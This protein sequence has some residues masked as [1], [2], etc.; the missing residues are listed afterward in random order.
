MDYPSYMTFGV[1]SQSGPTEKQRA[2]QTFKFRFFAKGYSKTLCSKY[3]FNIDKLNN[4]NPDFS[5]NASVSGKDI[6]YS[7][8]AKILIECAIVLLQEKDRINEGDLTK[9]LP[10][11]KGGVFTPSTDLLILH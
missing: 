9:G 7:G 1:F 4:L 10:A 2:S 11:I 8:T 5:I 3:N 6:A